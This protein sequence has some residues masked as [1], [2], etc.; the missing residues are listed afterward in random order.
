MDTV[1]RKSRNGGSLD[2]A[3]IGVDKRKG[4]VSGLTHV[5]GRLLGQIRNKLGL[6]RIFL[7]S[8]MTKKIADPFK[9]CIII[10]YQ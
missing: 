5:N 10:L 1:S 9:I 3:Q 6:F 4:R 7:Q 2:I 8:R